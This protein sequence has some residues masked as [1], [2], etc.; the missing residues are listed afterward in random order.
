M[1]TS[2]VFELVKNMALLG[3]YATSVNIKSKREAEAKRKELEAASLIKKQEQD[4][5]LLKQ[6]QKS[7]LDQRNEFLNSQVSDVYNMPDGTKAYVRQNSP[8]RP[9]EGGTLVGTFSNKSGFTPSPVKE[10]HVPAYMVGGQPVPAN[11]LPASAFRTGM[12]GPVV[13]Q[14]S[15]KDGTFKGFSAD[16]LAITNPDKVSKRTSHYVGGR[17]YS[18]YEEAYRVAT[19]NN[20]KI[21]VREDV[22]V[23]NQF[24]RTST[25]TFTPSENAGVEK[26]FGF[27]EVPEPDGGMKRVTVSRY[28]EKELRAIPGVVYQGKTRFIGDQPVRIPTIDIEKRS[29]VQLTLSDGTTVMESEATP[30]QRLDAVSQLRGTVD[31]DGNFDAATIISSVPDMTSTSDKAAALAL[32]KFDRVHKFSNGNFIGINDGVSARQNLIN[33]I[34]PGVTENLDILKNEPGE[35]AKFIGAFG[36]VIAD[37]FQQSADPSNTLGPD[38]TVPIRQRVANANAGILYEVPGM[39][40]I[41]AS[42]QMEGAAEKAIK[43]SNSIVLAEQASG[44]TA[45]E[46]VVQVENI[47]DDQTGAVKNTLYIGKVIPQQHTGFVKNVLRPKLLGL[48]NDAKKTNNLISS[49]IQDKKD[50]ITNETIFQ[51]IDGK[52]HP[53][54]SETQLPLDGLKSMAN[55]IIVPGR[56]TQVG[57]PS[58]PKAVNVV[59]PITQLDGF[60]AMV[61]MSSE[62]MQSTLA[63]VTPDIKEQISNKVIAIANDDLETLTFLIEPMIQQGGYRHNR[64]LRDFYGWGNSA[65]AEKIRLDQKLV[66]VAATRGIGVG[67][68]VLKAF[69]NPRTGERLDNTALGNLE[70]V[71]RGLVYVAGY[72]GD[73]AKSFLPGMASNLNTDNLK[74]Y[75]NALMQ[76]FQENAILDRLIIQ[77]DPNVKGGNPFAPGAT[78]DTEIK[79]SQALFEKAK[80]IKNA[81]ERAEA[82]A[83]AVREFHITVLAYELA[84]AIQ[85]GTGGRT[86]SD[87]DVKLIMD[88]L[89]Q[90]IAATP[91]EQMAAIRAAKDML[92]NLKVRAQ[93][94][95]SRDA[96]K[97]ATIA[98]ADDFMSRGNYIQITP[99]L[100]AAKLS[101]SMYPTTTQIISDMSDEDLLK[102][103][104]RQLSVRGEPTVTELT[105]EIKN[106]ELFKSSVEGLRGS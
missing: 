67:N 12:L 72:I 76:Q 82:E 22:Y 8:M 15:T 20:Q 32:A 2:A 25:N 23:N 39:D 3:G 58:D 61:N 95:G 64:R 55:T 11:K 77:Q 66:G 59:P 75:G 49:L 47:V 40:K 10:N 100:A 85:G 78:L 44:N 29:D 79:K 99:T 103:Y 74:Q 45:S 53:M 27:I 4:F 84:A 51:N 28:N 36:S 96:I 69:I 13:G 38:F 18:S 48:T 80:E 102:V 42:L 57:P 86:I 90:R 50:P 71:A 94:L 37:A 87:Q 91:D 101:Q 70:N 62:E 56:T 5:E 19:A 106:S 6:E 30:E 73:K 60:F 17:M 104:N 1:G 7:I 14:F 105:D 9:P 21:E 92:T 93:Y 16:I 35:A 83:Y 46:A 31:A 33:A 34:L 81:E 98:V 52:Q 89:K 24:D 26:H 41:F 65:Q 88:S 54:M 63:A 97:N 43:L 68:N